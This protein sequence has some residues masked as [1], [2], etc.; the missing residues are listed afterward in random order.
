MLVGV[1]EGRGGAGE[2]MCRGIQA[3]C[4]ELEEPLC[5]LK[6]F[7]EAGEAIQASARCCEAEQM[8]SLRVS[9]LRAISFITTSP[10][11]SQTH[12]HGIGTCCVTFGLFS[13]TT[14]ANFLNAWI[15]LTFK[16]IRENF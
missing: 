4:D 10:Q 3:F 9:A 16:A 14:Q 7:F 15:R 1:R 12:V 8:T 2:T 11:I 6:L 13:I 5:F